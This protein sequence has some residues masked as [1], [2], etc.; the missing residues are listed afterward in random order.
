MARELGS[1]VPMMAREVVSVEPMMA[2]EVGSVVP[3][4]PFPQTVPAQL[5][6]TRLFLRFNPQNLV[7]GSLTSVEVPET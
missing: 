6:S 5:A 3:I 7:S 2:R 4:T 1:V